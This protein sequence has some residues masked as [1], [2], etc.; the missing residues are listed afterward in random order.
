MCYLVEN[1]VCKATSC[2]FT[3][4]D[5]GGYNVTCPEGVEAGTCGQARPNGEQLQA[6]DQEIGRNYGRPPTAPIVLRD[7]DQRQ[8]PKRGYEPSHWW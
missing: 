6:A 5:G 3:P 7:P 1:G 8:R 2:V 4:A